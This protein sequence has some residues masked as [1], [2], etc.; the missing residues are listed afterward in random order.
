MAQLPLNRDCSN[1]PWG[2][3][4]TTTPPTHTFRVLTKNMN[5]LSPAV[6]WRAA[7]AALHDNAVQVACLSET[8]L[9]WTTPIAHHINQ[10][11]RK[12]PSKQTKIVTSNSMEVTTS[13]YQPGARAL[14]SSMES[15]GI[16][17]L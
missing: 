8:N 2:D 4:F 3:L 11:F 16:L 17:G 9:Q 15:Q 7:A 13:N 10:I 1:L 6:E 5:T 14:L 12:L